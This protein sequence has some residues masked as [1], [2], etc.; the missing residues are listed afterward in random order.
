[1]GLSEDQVS[2]IKIRLPTAHLGFQTHQCPRCVN[3][4][5]GPSGAHNFA[6]DHRSLCPDSARVHLHTNKHTDACTQTH[7]HRHQFSS[8]NPL[9]LT[10]CDPRDCS[11][12]AS[13]SITNSWSLLKLMSIKSVM[14]SN[15]LILCCPL[16]LLPSI[17]LSIRVFSNESAL[18][19]RWPKYWSFSSVSILPMNMQD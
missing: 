4:W 18:H 15:H 2:F 17:F 16:L 12:Q 8:V 10:L 7:T 3:I 5:H 6:G 1:M 13:L 9:C 11:T 14:P 19:I